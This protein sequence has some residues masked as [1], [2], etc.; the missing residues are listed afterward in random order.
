M[1]V[2]L[3]GRDRET[4]PQNWGKDECSQIQRGLWSKPAPEWISYNLRLGQRFTFQHDNDPKHTAK[5]RLEWLWDKSLTVLEWPSQSSDLKPVEHLWRDLKMAV[6]RRFLPEI[7]CKEECDKL[8]KST[9]AKLVETDLRLTVKDLKQVF[10]LSLWVIEDRLIFRGNYIL[11]IILFITNYF[12]WHMHIQWDH[13][14][15]WNVFI[16]LEWTL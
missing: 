7:I 15:K 3:S 14:I 5:T 6:H 4:V 2:L 11:T 10:S 8:S 13:W 1:G 16:N 12:L 9:C